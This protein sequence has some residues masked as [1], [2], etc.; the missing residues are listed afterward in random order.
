[1]G[2]KSGAASN[3][4]RSQCQRARRQR[5]R[6]HAQAKL[7]PRA[8]ANT[9]ALILDVLLVVMRAICPS[10]LRGGGKV[11]CAG[12]S[13]FVIEPCSGRLLFREEPRYAMH[14]PTNCQPVGR[15]D[16]PVA[17]LSAVAIC[18]AIRIGSSGSR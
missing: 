4:G 7:W 8:R 9:R 10:C 5:H 1:M 15:S 2:R 16:R 14:A 17:A 3:S 18:D 13:G 11:P 6:S 12:Y